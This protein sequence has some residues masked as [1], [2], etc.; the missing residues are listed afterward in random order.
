MD[1]FFADENLCAV[2]L[3]S[4]IILQVAQCTIMK[5]SSDTAVFGCLWPGTPIHAN[6]RLDLLQVIDCFYLEVHKDAKEGRSVAGV[7]PTLEIHQEKGLWIHVEY[8]FSDT[9]HK[10]GNIGNVG[11]TYWRNN[12]KVLVPEDSFKT[13]NIKTF[14]S[15]L[16][17]CHYLG[18]VTKFCFKY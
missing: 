10:W 11:F 18:T 3:T 14:L 6:T 15:L 13:F 7:C 2:C 9:W 16:F 12:V 17:L 5:G 8:V 1:V 4:K